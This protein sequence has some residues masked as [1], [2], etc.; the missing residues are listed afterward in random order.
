MAA[1]RHLEFIIKTIAQE[2][3]PIDHAHEQA[4]KRVKGVGGI[5]GLT[6]NPIL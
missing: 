4:N 2:S 3:L 5:I 1:V 6:E